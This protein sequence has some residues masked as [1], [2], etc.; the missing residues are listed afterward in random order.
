MKNGFWLL[1]GLFFACLHS[2]LLWQQWW[3]FL[4]CSWFVWVYWL[5][6]FPR[7]WR[8]I[9]ILASFI[10]VFLFQ[11]QKLQVAPVN[12]QQINYQ[13]EVH[14]DDLK[15]N[16]EMLSGQAQIN[17]EKIYFNCI[18]KD[19]QT[20][21]KVKQA[22]TRFVI[23]G[24]GILKIPEPKRNRFSFDFGHFL[25]T[26]GIKYTLFLENPKI[27]NIHA[28]T[29]LKETIIS[30]VKTFHLFLVR[31]FEQLPVGLRDYGETL[32]LGYT[33]A[34]FYQ[35]NLGIQKMGLVHL[36]S[37]S[38]FQVT[39]FYKLWRKFGRWI[40]LT[41]EINLIS[42]QAG[43][44]LLWIFA[45][46][47][48]SLIRPI[49]LAGFNTWRE[50]GWIK[51]SA[52]ELWGLS[53]IFGLL[54]EPGVLQT[55]GGQLS[56]LLA[57]GLILL[58]QQPAWQ[59]SLGLGLLIVPV[60]IWHTYE[61]HPLALGMN[62][63]AVPF[64]TWVILPVILI[65]VACSIF[66]ITFFVEFCN[67]II[68]WFR[69]IL[70]S[71]EN[72]PGNLTFGAISI[73]FGT[74]LLFL[75]LRLFERTNWARLHWVIGFII[76]LAIAPNLNPTGRVVFLDVGQ[77]DA[78]LFIQ[79]FKRAVVMLDVG[80]KVTFPSKE[81]NKAPRKQNRL[82]QEVVRNLKGFGVT[83]LDQVILTHKDFDHIG[84]L[85]DVGQEIKMQQIIVPAGMEQNQ[86][87]QSMIRG[88]GAQTIPVTAGSQSCS[89][90][91]I[92][93]PFESG[94][95]E[96]EDSIAGV[97][98]L[99]PLKMMFTGDLDQAGELKILQNVQVPKVDVLKFGHHGSKT[100]TA[101]EFVAA[102]EPRIGVV[103]AGVDNR[104]HHPNKETII[105]AKNAKMGVFS[106]QKNGMVEYK[107]LG[108][109]F[110]WRTQ[111]DGSDITDN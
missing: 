46:G 31:W 102:L 95:G 76:F 69:A 39:I 6:G 36:F 32:L 41:R 13:L 19:E 45:G 57:F 4:P 75:V 37:I 62:L 101:P 105:T 29:D 11:F 47:V 84:N 104:Y 16:G 28:P 81:D 109:K 83:K 20:I 97:G 9:C 25:K 26:R 90:L 38:G 94:T 61:W 12:G 54:I 24:Q 82:A 89:V 73:G 68:I 18:L 55:L 63:I 17:D 64:F 110:W 80:G 8:L 1:L 98:K 59:A 66:R 60:L 48:I 52:S 43:L 100:S 21:E 40:G 3:C 23:N 27:L 53:L 79:P 65:G 77:G 71:M 74:I 50:A 33:R 58:D 7:D 56:Y 111:M 108:N 49:L 2:A 42:L 72:I 86:M 103:S 5:Q 87:Y 88:L 67:Q 14:P 96:N 92:V 34:D 10:L 15:V 107:W 35:D 99:G 91:S 22:Q 30:A 70:G 51:L 78:T 85:R 44:L 93:H 106:T